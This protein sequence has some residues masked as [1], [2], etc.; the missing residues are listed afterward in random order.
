M[1]PGK[2]WILWVK[3]SGPG[4]SWK[5]GWSWKVREI[6]VQGFGK[7][8]NFLSHDVGVGHSDAG[9]DAAVCVSANL[10]RLCRF[11]SR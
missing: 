11:F 8:W 10:C 3:F 7:D 2:F 9:A 4:K 6:L 1:P 5:I